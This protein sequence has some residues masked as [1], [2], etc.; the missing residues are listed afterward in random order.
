MK[1]KFVML[2]VCQRLPASAMTDFARRLSIPHEKVQQINNDFVM[3]E[4]RYYQVCMSAVVCVVGRFALISNYFVSCY[5][6]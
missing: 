1:H 4:E 2:D 6:M 5:L 3:Q